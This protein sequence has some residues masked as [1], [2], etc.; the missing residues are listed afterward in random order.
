MLVNGVAGLCYST[1]HGVSASFILGLRSPGFLSAASLSVCFPS[2]LGVGFKRQ[3]GSI[4]LCQTHV[5]GHKSGV[6]TC[7]I[8]GFRRRG[9][10]RSFSPSLCALRKSHVRT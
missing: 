8:S 1:W 2:H 7:R 3:R 4:L 9:R 10:K 6:L 5:I